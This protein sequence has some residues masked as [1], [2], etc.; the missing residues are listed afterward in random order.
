M[1]VSV[2]IY[3]NMCVL[4]HFGHVLLFATLWTVAL[5]GPLFTGFS[6][7]GYWSE[8]LPDPGIEF[9]PP[10]SPALRQILYD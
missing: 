5:Q 3:M 2:C 6:R 1:C 7:Q 9:M 10:V 8:L 4:C